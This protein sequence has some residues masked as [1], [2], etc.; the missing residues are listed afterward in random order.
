MDLITPPRPAVT[1]DLWPHPLTADGRRTRVR[2]VPPGANLQTLI[3]AEWP[4]AADHL[5]AA[6]DGRPVPREAWR[7]T[8][9][10]D[11]QIVTL[12]G[13]LA[14]DDSDPLRVLLQ[15]VV[16][17]AA[18]Y[19]AGLWPGIAFGTVTWGQLASA[20]VLIAGQLIINAIA[21]PR[22][23]DRP[24]RA[25]PEPVYSLT[26]GANRA[27]PYEPLLLV[28]GSH[29]VFPDLG[30]AGYTEYAG[31][32][33]FLHSI[34][35]FGLGDLD[36]EDLRIGDSELDDFEEVETQWAG[37]DGALTLVAGNVDTEAGAALEGTD[38]VQ[39]TSADD[40]DLIGI[41]LTGSLFQVSGGGDVQRRTVTIEVEYWPEGDTTDKETATVTLEHAATSP[42]R[43]TL[44]YHLDETGTWVVRIKRTTAPSTS[45]RVHDDIVWAALRSYQP[46]S[47]DYTGQTRLAVR[48]RAT[49][50]LSGR[51]NRL[52]ASVSQ[53]IPVWNG[54]AWSAPQ[55]SSNPAWL[56]RWYAR[57]I[58]IGSSL[59]A[60]IGLAASRIDDDVIK[61]WG[62]WCD[63]KELGCNLVID[64]ARSHAEVLTTIAQCGRASPSW[65]TGRLGVVWDQAAQPVTA[66]FTPA[67]VVA[68]SF[69]VDY[70]AGKA[71]DEIVC[72]YVDPDLDWQ[73]NSVRRTVPGATTPDNSVTL[74]LTGVT[75]RE[76]AAAECNLQAARQVYHRRRLRWE[77]GAEGLAVARGDVVRLTHGLIDGGSAGRLLGG[78]TTA[79]TLSRT[80]SL[81][82]ASD[83]ML[84]GLPDGTLHTSAVNHSDGAGTAGETDRVT[85]VT[86]L[87]AAPDAD[88]TS[89]LDTLWRY[90]AGDAEPAKVRIVGLEPTADRRVRIEAIDE[91]DAYYDAATADLTVPLP[92]PQVRRPEVVHI[93]LTE[94]LIRAGRGFAVE[95]HVALTVAGD[96][97]GGTIRATLD[98]GPARTVARL[99]DGATAASWISPPSGTLT[100]TAIPGSDAFPVGT[101]L[102][103]DYTI[104][105]KLAPPADVTGFLIEVLGDGTRR[106]RWNPV[107]EPDL[108]GYR[109]RYT[110][111]VAGTTPTWDDMTP[112][113]DGLVTWAPF[114]TNEP[115]AGDWTF[116]VRAEDTSGLLSTTMTTIIAELSNPRLG[117]SILWQCPSAEGWPDT[118]AGAVLSSDGTNALESEGDYSWSDLTTWT[119]W[120]SWA[121]GDGNDGI[122]GLSYTTAAIDLGAKIPFTIAWQGKSTGTMHAEY[123]VA[124]TAAALANAS[125][126][127]IAANTLLTTR[128]LQLR[129]RLTGGGSTV[130]RLA[131][132]CW[133]LLGTVFQEKYLDVDTSD[134][135]GSASGGRQIP[136]SL[137]L[138]TDVHLTLQS[139]GAGWT[140]ELDNKNNPTRIKIYD[141]DGDGADA[142]VDVV[143]SGVKT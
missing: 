24:E 132:L 46:D 70:V 113:H 125:W 55:V 7:S 56:Y 122:A 43:Q 118:I 140:W 112:L 67:N 141:D 107:A 9:L 110:A 139:V 108:A 94:T 10:T 115:A 121:L 69:E 85:L 95:I 64:R 82:G 44:V 1:A 35:H 51:L 16:L 54:T 92:S 63:Q 39:R 12:R 68:G 6:V 42:F 23:P 38:W 109:I 78:T 83:Y 14:G 101:S 66:L 8:E 59:V 116:G 52:S 34:F 76:Q 26:G 106:L 61:L 4:G 47:G 41:D 50:Q 86:A 131:Y 60:G 20:A 58:K 5:V 91:V 114:E 65:G 133:W 18:F 117:A 96:W 48:I 13:A 53:K 71:A 32:N 57:G 89:P 73:W 15:I 36:I 97:R 103:V 27:R 138:V 120:T 31:V 2:A 98:G 134:W 22:L 62:A 74:T 75:D 87:P 79:L 135:Q 17:V 3:A 119:A 111:T 49:G 93:T 81:S 99:V 102:T 104:Q 123:R 45:D 100:V 80:I 19:V 21:P 28:L 130:L 84:L 40:T 72:R 127:A 137:D 25:R 29:R 105:G 136:T 11:G 142:T 37:A 88:G 129:W 33:Q 77:A 30:A 90:Y 124:A 126:T 128:H 143:V